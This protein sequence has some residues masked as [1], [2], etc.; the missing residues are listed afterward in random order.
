[1]APRAQQD[2]VARVGGGCGMSARVKK[3]PYRPR[4]YDYVMSV[5]DMSKHVG[6]AE[7]SLRYLAELQIIRITKDG[8]ASSEIEKITSDLA[9][10]ALQK[11]K[12]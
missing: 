1:M 12:K 4:Q 7:E 11:R 8:I 9:W 3:H 2:R 6:Y 10:Q 5:P